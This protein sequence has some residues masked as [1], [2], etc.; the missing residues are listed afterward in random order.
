MT[1]YLCHLHKPLWSFLKI[2]WPSEGYWPGRGIAVGENKK[3]F[4]LCQPRSSNLSTTGIQ[5]GMGKPQEQGCKERGG[6]RLCGTIFQ[7]HVGRAGGT[8]VAPHSLSDDGVLMCWLSAQGVSSSAQ[9]RCCLCLPVSA[10]VCPAKRK[11]P[12]AVTLLLTAALQSAHS[13]FLQQKAVFTPTR[14]HLA[15]SN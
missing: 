11:T 7:S 12:G 14:F 2:P 6:A 3:V 10:C 9:G 13:L 5:A 4:Q 1:S 15:F 8:T